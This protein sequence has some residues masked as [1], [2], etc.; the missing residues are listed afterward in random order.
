MPG[1]NPWMKDLSFYPLQPE[2]W[3]DFDDLFGEHGA[4][5]GCWCMWWRLTRAE[6]QR[7]LGEENRLAMKAVVEGY[8]IEVTR[9][10]TGSSGYTGIVPVFIRAGFKEVDRRSE[11]QLVMRYFVVD[12]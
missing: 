7:M 3:D 10:L 8:P 1:E 6:F 2:R 11:H 5:E 12:S 9:K 4:F